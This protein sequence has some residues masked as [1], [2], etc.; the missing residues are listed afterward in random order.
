MMNGGYFS[1]TSLAEKGILVPK[2]SEKLA[3]VALQYSEFL[4]GFSF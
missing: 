1:E 4:T 2:L 3:S